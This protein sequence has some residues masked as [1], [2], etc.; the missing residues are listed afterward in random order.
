MSCAAA[1]GSPWSMALRMRVTSFMAGPGAGDTDA[2]AAVYCGGPR[3]ASIL[4][5]YPDGITRQLGE[6]KARGR[7][8]YPTTRSMRRI[9]FPPAQGSRFRKEGDGPGA[10]RLPLVSAGLQAGEQVV[11][12]DRVDRAEPVRA[13][14]GCQSRAGGRRLLH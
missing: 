12:E 3:R 13:A 14:V 7:E 4:T 9:R 10:R 2:R 1:W 5:P 11:G 8:A 6:R